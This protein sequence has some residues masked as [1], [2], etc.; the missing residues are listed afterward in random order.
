MITQEL[1]HSRVLLKY[2]EGQRKLVTLTSEVE[3]NSL[4]EI[5]LWI[6]YRMHLKLLDVRVCNASVPGENFMECFLDGA[7]F[8]ITI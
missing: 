5:S 6:V 8:L 7:Y 4:Y 1:L 3:A 2:G